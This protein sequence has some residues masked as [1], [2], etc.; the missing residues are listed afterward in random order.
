MNLRTCDGEQLPQRLLLCEMTYQQDGEQ[1]AGNAQMRET[2]MMKRKI[3]GEERRGQKRINARDADAND[4]TL[5]ARGSGR[6][7]VIR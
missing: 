5:E 7:R 1:R 2:Q 6:R 3:I 4:A